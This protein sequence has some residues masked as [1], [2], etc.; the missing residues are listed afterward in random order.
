M[1]SSKATRRPPAQWHEGARIKLG[2]GGPE[3]RSPHPVGGLRA[4]CKK[5]RQTPILIVP[6]SP[7]FPH[8]SALATRR[9]GAVLR[10][11]TCGVGRLER[12]A[13]ER[14]GARRT[15]AKSVDRPLFLLYQFSPTFS[16]SPHSALRGRAEGAR[17]G[18]GGSSAALAAWVVRVRVG[19]LGSGSRPRGANTGPPGWGFRV[20]G[21]GFRVGV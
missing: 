13:Q 18:F 8:R 16:H 6:V 17:L 5:C 9:S 21:L 3:R 20:R 15:S 14:I 11:R 12:R 7:T 2:F 10:P 19:G 4:L 1:Y